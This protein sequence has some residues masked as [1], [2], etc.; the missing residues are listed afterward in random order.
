MTLAPTSQKGPTMTFRSEEELAG[1]KAGR[2][3]AQRVIA[4]ESS[5]GHVD[6]DELLIDTW[7]AATALFGDKLKLNLSLYE[8][9]TRWDAF[10]RSFYETLRERTLAAS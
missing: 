10:R 2:F 5:G 6:D 1:I 8:T 4:C 7:D 3:L 9:Q